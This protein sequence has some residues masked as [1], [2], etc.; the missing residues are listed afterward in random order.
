MHAAATS[1]AATAGTNRRLQQHTPPHRHL[2]PLHPTSLAPG[3]PQVASTALSA[4]PTSLHQ[5][6][7][8]PSAPPSASHMSCPHICPPPGTIDSTKYPY[9]HQ[10]SLLGMEVTASTTWKSLSHRA[11]APPAPA[12]S[13]KGYKVCITHTAATQPTQLLVTNGQHPPSVPHLNA[14]PQQHNRPF[15][16]CRRLSPASPQHLNTTPVSTQGREAQP[17]DNSCSADN[18]LPKVVTEGGI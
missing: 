2:I 12:N 13:Y 7:H 8:P 9:H 15:S 5:A 6:W 14:T 11:P 3:T 16:S 17:P 10:L 1:L 4:T 18:P